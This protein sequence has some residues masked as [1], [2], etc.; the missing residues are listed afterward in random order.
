M[1]STAVSA[2]PNANFTML[3]GSSVHTNQE[4]RYLEYRRRWMEN[5]R[6]FVVEDFPIHLDIEAT[7]RCNLKMCFL[8]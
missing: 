8:R 7:N 3:A 1:S 2:E 5:P 4:P 6:N